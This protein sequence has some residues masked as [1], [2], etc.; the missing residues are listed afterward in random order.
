MRYILLTLSAILM[1]TPPIPAEEPPEANAQSGAV[2]SLSDNR[3]AENWL[4]LG[5]IAS[6]ALPERLADGVSARAFH[7]DYLGGEASARLEAG[8]PVTL[9]TG[10]K[11]TPT[12]MGISQTGWNKGAVGGRS[13][14]GTAHYFY[15]EID[16]PADEVR[17][18]YMDFEGSP[19]VW[20]NGEL[21]LS[22]WRDT[23]I[24]RPRDYG[25]RVELRR[26]RNRCLVKLDSKQTWWL[27]RLEFLTKGQYDR[28]VVPNVERLLVTAL[29]PRSVA[30][31]SVPATFHGEYR[32]SAEI[33]TPDGKA[34]AMARGTCGD[35]VPLFLQ[36]GKSME[37]GRVYY[38]DLKPAMEQIGPVRM[39][40]PCGRTAD[41]LRRVRKLREPA[42][43]KA[44]KLPAPW[45]K[46]CRAA[47]TWIDRALKSQS[48]GESPASREELYYI[49]QVLQGL[50]AGRNPLAELKGLQVPVW[51]EWTDAAGQ[52]R[53]GNYAI[54]LPVDYGSSEQAAPLLYTLTGGSY[55]QKEVTVKFA[56]VDMDKVRFEVD[57]A[58]ALD[59]RWLTVR[60]ANLT[61][62]WDV[63][64]L[65]A[66]HAHIAAHVTLDAGRVY[67]HGGSLG[68]RG[69][70]NWAGM[71]P[72]RFAAVIARSGIGS[73]VLSPRMTEIPIWVICGGRDRMVANAEVGVARVQDAGGI[74]RYTLLPHNSH[75]GGKDE[76]PVEKQRDWLLKHTLPN[77]P[78]AEVDLRK[79]YG[80]D[81]GGMSAITQKAVGAYLSLSTRLRDTTI[82]KALSDQR[83]LRGMVFRLQQPSRGSGRLLGR[84]AVLVRTASGECRLEM[85]LPAKIDPAMLPPESQQ[86]KTQGHRCLSV[87]T[88]AVDIDPAKV[89]ATLRAKAKEEGLEASGEVRVVLI[90]PVSLLSQPPMTEWHLVLE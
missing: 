6:M 63:P 68:G 33:L 10:Q 66:V 56:G 76:V 62:E 30:V 31:Q 32:W 81:A 22:S 26:G 37:L 16:M 46:V 58:M 89:I 23:H 83:G 55:R 85:P 47:F 35:A 74:L 48:L 41:G 65:E 73:V 57:R 4:H 79:H 21:I 45:P 90:A 69:T 8:K 70:W 39:L 17:Y 44:S 86:G 53:P 29:G 42:G 24:L 50:V 51:F 19:K 13:H 71:V 14:A 49:E 12:P 67:C 36:V 1:T 72:N 43:Q 78:R 5:P 34:V 75:G 15:C 11:L 28:E 82:E 54:I 3:F 87:T 60:P 61:G 77:K 64:M 38:A 52:K 80:L 88:L 59:D 18:L 27:A 20:L 40:T 25:V 7:T 9:S 84:P 2:N